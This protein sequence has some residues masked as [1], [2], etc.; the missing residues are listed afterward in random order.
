MAFPHRQSD[1]PQRKCFSAENR[2]QTL[3]SA[4]LMLVSHH[5][6]LPCVCLL[7]YRVCSKMSGSNM[8]LDRCSQQGSV[9]SPAS[10]PRGL[11]SAGLPAASA[12]NLTAD[13]GKY[14]YALI[15]SQVPRVEADPSAPLNACTGS[16]RIVSVG[17]AI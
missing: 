11:G 7:H 8:E 6:P 12:D 13:T 9:E 14:Q 1:A 16:P 10:S 15:F 5:I 4:R 2:R 17:Y 3:H